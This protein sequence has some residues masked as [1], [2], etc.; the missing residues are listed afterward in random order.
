MLLAF[1]DR[2]NT[3]RSA[4]CAGIHAHLRQTGLKLMTMK[5]KISE[6]APNLEAVLVPHR[7]IAYDALTDVLMDA[8]E[9]VLL[10][11]KKEEAD[12]GFEFDKR[13]CGFRPEQMERLTKCED[14]EKLLHWISGMSE[15]ERLSLLMAFLNWDEIRMREFR[16]RFPNSF[17]KWSTSDDDEL[18]RMYAAGSTWRSLSNHFGRNVNAIKLRLQHLGIDLGADAASA[19]FP[20]RTVIAAPR[21]QAAQAPA[22]GASEAQA[23]A[24]QTPAGAPQTPPAAAVLPPG[25]PAAPIPS[26]FGTELPFAEM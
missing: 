23:G 1:A 19:R 11:L 25:A 18:R 2:I 4:D 22:G 9:E 3:N 16:A 7:S 24:A 8:L 10:L 20:R 17:M 6:L 12:E 13:V 21:G 14:S 15:Q 26:P 5:K